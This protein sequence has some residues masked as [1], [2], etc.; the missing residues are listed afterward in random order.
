MNG[1]SAVLNCAIHLTTTRRTLFLEALLLFHIT[2]GFELRFSIRFGGEQE[3]ALKFT[4]PF[5]FG[6]LLCARACV[7]IATGPWGNK[8]DTVYLRSI[9]AASS[10]LILVC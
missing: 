4:V 3:K 6:M 1:V 8:M 9:V 7:S 2:F 10:A 5:T